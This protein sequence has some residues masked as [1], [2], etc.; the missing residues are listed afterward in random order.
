MGLRA[1]TTSLSWPDLK[2]CPGGLRGKKVFC[3]LPSQ[4]NND[5]QEKKKK[6]KG[7]V[8]RC[9]FVYFPWTVS[10]GAPLLG[11][12]EFLSVPAFYCRAW[13]CLTRNHFASLLAGAR[14]TFWMQGACKLN[15][16]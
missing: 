7:K 6:K 3:Q 16:V 11:V 2:G 10:L 14:L 4:T 13:P 1:C 12:R 9:F 8:G 5:V 15:S